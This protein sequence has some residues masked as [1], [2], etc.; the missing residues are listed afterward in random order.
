MKRKWWH[1]KIVYQVYPKS[2]YDADGNGI[3]DVR[4]VTEKLDYLKDLG[5]D[6]VW[7]SPVYQSPMADQ[8]YDISDYYKIDPSFGTIQDMEELI[9][10]AKKRGIHIL[11]DL[12]ANHC[13]DEHEWFRQACEDPTGKYGKYF[14]IRDKKA[15]GSMPT[16]WR[17]YFGGSSWDE[18]PG[19]P[20]KVYLHVFHKKQPD[21]NWENPEVR[22]EIYRNINWWMEKGL[23]GF[24][25]DAIMN[26][27]KPKVFRDYEP[28]R[29]D[30]LSSLVYMLDDAEGIGDFLGEMKQRTFEKYDAFTV[31]EAMSGRQDLEAFI[32]ENGYMSSIFDFE[33]NSYGRSPKGW[34]AWKECLPENY[35]RCVFKAQERIGKTGFLSNIIE[36][37]DEP[38]GVSRYIPAQEINETSKKALA[39]AY[40]FL[41][42]IPFIYQG[43]EIGMENK[44]FH[45][46]DEV[47]DVGTIDQ[48]RI[49]LNA[50]CT[51]EEALHTITRFSRDNART[52]MQWTE[53]ENSG[54]TVGT[55]WLPVNE[56]YKI[57]NVE[58]SLRDPNSVLNF[59][60]E[61]IRLR[62]NPTYKDTLVYG[63]FEH[64]MTEIPNLMAYRRKSVRAGEVSGITE[65]TPEIVVM[66]NMKTE[67]QMVP[68]SE[69]VGKLLLNN[70]GEL[71]VSGEYM[72]LM[73]WQAVVFGQIK[74]AVAKT[75]FTTQQSIMS[76]KQNASG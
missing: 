25:I 67:T 26:I 54:F 38:R 62:K 16:N 69:A 34:Y 57:I 33:E 73:P 21:L 14:Y 66:I 32:G 13:S 45:S 7:L 65:N 70:L 6:I 5:I 17:S 31:G 76:K 53:G 11:M 19:H 75:Y 10:E 47:D 74:E 2:F 18:L 61:M 27:K 64:R 71:T 39:C 46:A 49:A 55:P 9:A 20:E 68:T 48:Y 56:N 1:D 72:T 41:R 29:G 8:G 28:D 36:N 37:H 50:G 24:R 3:G 44:V 23:G 35:K 42:G 12:V 52:P 63:E 59:Y 43:Q 58:K 60:Q 30:G 51:V 40:F 4:G 22:E 15:D